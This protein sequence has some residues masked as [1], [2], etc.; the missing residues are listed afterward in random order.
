MFIALNARSRAEAG[1][2]GMTRPSPPVCCVLIDDQIKECGIDAD[3]D[4]LLRRQIVGGHKWRP[5]PTGGA[6]SSQSRNVPSA[7]GCGADEKLETYLI[8]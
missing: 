6:L 2:A 7:Q 8:V 5:P 1:R 3:V 4:R